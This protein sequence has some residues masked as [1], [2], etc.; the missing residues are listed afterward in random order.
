MFYTVIVILP[1][2]CKTE[3]KQYKNV[4]SLCELKYS[5]VFLRVNQKLLPS[6]AMRVPYKVINGSAGQIIEEHCQRNRSF[7]RSD[8]HKI[9]PK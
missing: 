8:L 6:L 3:E 2:Q 1:I 4:W 9:R 5:F 7:I